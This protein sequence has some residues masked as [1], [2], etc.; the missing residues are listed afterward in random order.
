MRLDH[1]IVQT[2]GFSRN[3]A[4]Q[5]IEGGLV[6]IHGKTI[7]KTS[8]QVDGNE[9]ILLRDEK[10]VHWVSRSAG[11][12]DGFL[13]ELKE[14]GHDIL[15]NGKSALDIGSSTGGFTQVLLEHGIMH[16]DSVDVGTN[17]LHESIKGDPRVTSYERTDIRTFSP[18]L[19]LSNQ[20]SIYDIIVCDV[21]FISLHEII[22]DILRFS[23]IHTNIFLLFKPQFEVGKENLRKTGVP[24]NGDIV[25]QRLQEFEQL[26]NHNGLIIHKKSPST[27]LGEAGNEEWMIWVGRG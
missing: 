15:I 22:P 25:L 5:F 18:T 23:L 2:Y 11:K 21:S 3:K 12:L 10:S 1:S 20:S 6:S 9:E 24:R 8:Y 14:L 27:V 16:V 4:Q 17:Q 19:Q 26:L 13:N 7:T